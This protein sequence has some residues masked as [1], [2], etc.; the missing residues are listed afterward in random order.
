MKVRLESAGDSN[1]YC[2]IL[3]LSALK[4]IDSI[5]LR[6]LTFLA[7]AFTCDMR[8]FQEDNMNGLPKTFQEIS[9][10]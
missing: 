7:A 9:N 3:E 4:K 8:Y 6:F 2:K 5:K 10:D 1:P